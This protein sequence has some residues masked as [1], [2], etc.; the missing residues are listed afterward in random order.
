MIPIPVANQEEALLFYTE[1]LGLEK[2]S[3]LSLGP[4]LRL[5]TV[6]PKGQKR[7][8]LALVQP[9]EQ[10]AHGAILSQRNTQEAC[11]VFHTDDCQRMYERWLVRGVRFLNSP[12]RQSYGIEAL[13]ED[14]YGNVFALLEPLSV[15][16]T[17]TAYSRQGGSISMGHDPA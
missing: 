5:L 3:D 14:P 7:P 17:S 10:S 12:T 16:K 6:A 9:D 4:G 15:V 11:W 8:E 1:K 2:R 13:F